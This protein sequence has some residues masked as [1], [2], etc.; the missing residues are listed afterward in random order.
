MTRIVPETI[1]I[2]SGGYD[3]DT[4]IESDTILEFSPTNMNW[5]V[6]DTMKAARVEHAVTTIPLEEAK[7]LCTLA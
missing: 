3:E 1:L 2:L 5:T 7:K 4:N 6:L